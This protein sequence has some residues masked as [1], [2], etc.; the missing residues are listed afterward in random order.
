MVQ[1]FVIGLFAYLAAASAANDPLVLFRPADDPESLGA[2]A[3]HGIKCNCRALRNAN[4]RLLSQLRRERRQHAKEMASLVHQMQRRQDGLAAQMSAID[5]SQ[6]DRSISPAVT[7][8]GRSGGGEVTHKL[9]SGARQLL[10][11]DPEGRFCSQAEIETL[12]GTTPGQVSNA[13]DALL[14]SNLPCGMCIVNCAMSI[15]DW[16]SIRQTLQM[17]R[18]SQISHQI[19]SSS[20][21]LD[22]CL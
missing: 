1:S 21:P 2:G 14:I 15:P 20:P 22:N 11:P 7:H 4:V 17:V 9:R 5:T 10:Q 8:S 13:M 12:V 6:A 19:Y 16:E 3:S 18:A